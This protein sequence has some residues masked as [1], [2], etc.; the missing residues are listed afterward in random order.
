MIPPIVIPPLDPEERT[1]HE[2]EHLDVLH[3][4][5]DDLAEAMRKISKARE[6]IRNSTAVYEERQRGRA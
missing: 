1:E 6:R 4:A 2:Q 3:Q 5:D